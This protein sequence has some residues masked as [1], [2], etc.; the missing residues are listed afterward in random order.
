MAAP[1]QARTAQR[2][3][4]LVLGALLAGSGADAR[5]ARPYKHKAHRAPAP[6]EEFT[7]KPNPAGPIRFPDSRIEPVAWT[8]I[9]GWA[10]DD[11]AAA[12][13]TFS[14]SCRAV[15]GSA[16]SSR[17][18]RP[19]YPALVEV[20]RR[21]R[22][23]GQL[24]GAAARKFFETNFT[25]VSISKIDDPNGLL[26]GYYEPVVD[27]SRFPT[28]EFKVPLYRRPRDIVNMSRKRKADGFPNRGRV[29]RRINRLKYEPYYDRAAIEDG[30]LDG[31]HLEITYLK[32]FN[33]LLFMQIQGSARVRLED[34][35]VLR[36]NY[37]AHNG[38]PYT[39]VGRVLIERGLVP[40]E[41]MSM[42]RIRQWMADNPGGAAELRLQN[43]SYVFFRITG[44]SGDE[45]PKGAQGVPLTPARSIA[46]DRT[47]HVY[48][49]P[50]FIQ[51]ELPIDTDKSDTK[52]RKLMIAQDTGSA[53]VGPARA[54]IYFGAGADA[55]HIAG[56]VKNPA[57]FVMLLPRALDPVEAGKAMPL[58]LARPAS[59]PP[60]QPLEKSAQP[61][62]QPAAPAPEKPAAKP[63]TQTSVPLPPDKPLA[64]PVPLPSERPADAPAK[65]AVKPAEA[66]TDV[67]LP[68]DKPL[69]APV[70]Q[71]RPKP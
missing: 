28:G 27:G 14:A 71:P 54:D 20:C 39:P 32:D 63:E 46:V 1:R 50:F 26:T 21:L 58:P 16:K 4:V 41:E 59:A 24:D 9:E 49:T 18:A 36:V 17:D 60:P 19:V 31:K 6:A 23:A 48:G 43:K 25:P 33:D 44:L 2:I 7:G 38:H 65:P 55:G 10:G 64:G 69:A 34:G 67:P 13:A 3:A 51:A 70:P 42:Q 8:T 35:V 29:M 45:E 53:I 66:K 11:H 68:P 62:A 30:A 57:R 47:L 56:R 12:L 61:A 37:D 5:V 40:R 52:F 22:A 15:V